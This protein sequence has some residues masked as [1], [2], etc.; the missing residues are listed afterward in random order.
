MGVKDPVAKSKI[1][2][3]AAPFANRSYLGCLVSTARYSLTEAIKKIPTMNADHKMCDCQIV[4]ITTSLPTP[5]ISMSPIGMVVQP[6][7]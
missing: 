6:P 5:G 7:L 1:V 4:A 2:A 3:M